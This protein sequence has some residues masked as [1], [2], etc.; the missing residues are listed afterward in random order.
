MT[1]MKNAFVLNLGK[2]QTYMDLRHRLV[3]E[4]G[5]G[6]ASI[7]VAE[8]AEVIARNTKI[9]VLVVGAW[10]PKAERDQAV[11]IVKQNNLQATIIF[12]YDQNIDGAEEADAILNFRGD[13]SDLVRTVQH[14]LA[15]AKQGRGQN[16]GESKLKNLAGVTLWF[17]AACCETLPHLMAA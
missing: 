4:A 11:R 7:G 9:D 15:K 14:L 12:Y 17:S 3:A 6:V 16:R 8:E 13:Y 2:E 1:G 10:V 5:Y